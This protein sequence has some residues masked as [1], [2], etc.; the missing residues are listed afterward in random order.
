MAEASSAWRNN[1][2]K[3]LEDFHTIGSGGVLFPFGVFPVF[4]KKLK[5]G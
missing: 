2:R 3:T 1:E 5:G 4:S